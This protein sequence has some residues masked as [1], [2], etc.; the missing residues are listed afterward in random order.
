LPLPD[1][2]APCA[3][4]PAA[5]GYDP[6]LGQTPP[7]HWFCKVCGGEA[8]LTFTR[9]RTDGHLV[10]AA[11][12]PQGYERPYYRCPQCNLLFHVGFDV[13]PEEQRH[14][15]E[16]DGVGDAL[17]KQVNRGKRELLMV[18]AFLRLH[19]I[20]PREPVLVFGCGSGLSYNYMLGAGLNAYATDL[21]I[22]FKAAADAFKDYNFRRDLLP[23]MLHRFRKLEDIADGSLSLIT[24]TEVFEHFLDP[25]PLMARLARLLRPGGL[26][27]GTT[28]WVDKVEGDLKEWWYLKCLSHATFLSSKAFM[29][30]C[31]AAG[32]LG[33]LYPN[34]DTL[35]AGTGMSAT[36]C[37]FAMQRPL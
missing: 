20:P 15:Y 24:M 25:V 37:I 27:I 18:D 22:Q 9:S 29:H 36:Q 1:A 17:D 34:T 16:L 10:E 12:Q 8:D 7:G 5:S 33:T 23:A 32:C 21:S 6:A 11:V 13:L 14:V 3:P 4:R 19:H 28:G 30:I 26:L 31:A 2:A 35:K